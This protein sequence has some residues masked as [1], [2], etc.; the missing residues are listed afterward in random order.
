MTDAQHSAL[1]RISEIMREHF[2]AAVF[3]FEVD[4]GTDEDPTLQQLSYATSGSYSSSLGL[5]AY[6]NDRMLHDEHQNPV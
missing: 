6:A 4:A 3:I 1:D 5:V 2:G